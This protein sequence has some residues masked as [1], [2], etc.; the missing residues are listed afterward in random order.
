MNTITRTLQAYRQV[1]GQLDGL[2][3]SCYYLGQYYQ[4][5]GTTTKTET[6]T[7]VGGKKVSG[8][9]R[10]RQ[11]T[12]TVAPNDKAPNCSTPPSPS[13]V[14]KSAITVT[15]VQDQTSA[16]STIPCRIFTATN[17][18]VSPVTA[19]AGRTEPRPAKSRTPWT[20]VPLDFAE[21]EQ[22]PG[23]RATK[24]PGAVSLPTCDHRR[25]LTEIPDPAT[26]RFLKMTSTEGW[27]RCH[28]MRRPK[29]TVCS[30]TSSPAAADRL[31]RND[32]IIFLRS[33]KEKWS[34]GT[35]LVG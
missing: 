3:S 4:Y 16:A 29:N 34:I 23:D 18:P 13:S 10:A 27:I 22:S 15:R 17:H 31:Q 35:S 21:I 14:A 11:V 12:P 30:H 26:K 20:C 19:V 7:V 6:T 8:R 32:I 1:Y 28:R 5:L 24:W 9:R 25:L 33:T 2:D